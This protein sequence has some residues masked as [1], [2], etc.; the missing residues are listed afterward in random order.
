[1]ATGLIERLRA[2]LADV[3]PEGA[4]VVLTITA[5]I[6]LPS[7]TADDLEARVRRLLAR[8]PPGRDVTATVHGNGV[9]IGLVRDGSAGVPRVIGFVHNPG[10]DARRLVQMTREILS[11]L[12][13]DPGPRR[14]RRGGE[15]S[16]VVVSA[17]G[18]EWLTVYRAIEAQLG[19]STGSATLRIVFRDGEVGVTAPGALS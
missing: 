1:V 3:V 18:S 14:S 12:A 9:R 16:R 11:I 2:A 8:R 10:T 19:A 5:P 7:K 4:T 17:D 6:R 15:R 13:A